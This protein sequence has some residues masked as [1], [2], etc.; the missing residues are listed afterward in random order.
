MLLKDLVLYNIETL[1]K[2]I[3]DGKQLD[4]KLYGALAN[5]EVEHYYAD[6]INQVVYIFVALED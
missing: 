6:V 4:E 3:V 5:K 1:E 2:F